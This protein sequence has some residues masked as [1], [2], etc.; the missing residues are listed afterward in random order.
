MAGPGSSRSRRSAADAQAGDDRAVALD[1]LLHEV[2]EQTTALA[3]EQVEAAARVVVVR[4]GLEVLDEISD[5]LGQDGDLDISVEGIRSSYPR[6]EG[7]GSCRN[8]YFPR[9]LENK[10]LF[11]Q[12]SKMSREASGRM[13]R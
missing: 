2:V 9:G 4:V 11:P 13:V 1:V 7:D 10:T 3:D 8:E 12:T 6:S 5:A